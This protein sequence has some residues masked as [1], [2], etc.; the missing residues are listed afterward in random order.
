V[1]T[2]DNTYSYFLPTSRGDHTLK[3]GG[4]V[5]TNRMTPRG[6][7][8]SG[9]F[10]FDTDLPYDPTNPA[11]FPSRFVSQVGPCC[12]D[13]FNVIY[14]DLRNY[15]FVEDRWRASDRLT[16]NLGMRYDYQRQTSDSKDDFG[17]RVGA[18]YDLTGEGTT[19]LRAGFGRFNTVGVVT[20][21]LD[22]LQQ[23]VI[24]LFPTITLTAEDDEDSAVLRPDVTTSSAGDPGVAVLS[25]AGRANWRHAVQ[26][27]WP[28]RPS[29]ETRSSTGTTCRCSI[30]GAGAPVWRMNWARG[31]R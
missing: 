17:P 21:S 4:G 19:V 11:T 10:E 13:T 6:T 3:V 5:S 18:V 7:V 12:P 31:W 14:H 28:V 8:D 1:Y 23:G 15:F 20:Q 27:F 25:A 26:R 24:T 22:L 30:N 2:F 9:T 29:T 16:L